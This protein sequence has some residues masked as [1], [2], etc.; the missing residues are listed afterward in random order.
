MDLRET[1]VNK[2]CTAVREPCRKG[3]KVV[4]RPP[5]SVEV[6][7]CETGDVR[8]TPCLPIFPHLVI[9]VTLHDADGSSNCPASILM[10]RACSEPGVTQEL[11]WTSR[12][13]EHLTAPDVSSVCDCVNIPML[14][15][16]IDAPCKHQLYYIIGCHLTLI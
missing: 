14:F 5:E 16:Y 11:R 1:V 7:V 8:Q 6:F 2:H 12:H 13:I 15:N 10:Q 4:L 9:L 3:V